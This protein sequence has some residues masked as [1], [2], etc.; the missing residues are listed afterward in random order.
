MGLQAWQDRLLKG[1]GRI[2]T[3]DEFETN[4]LQ[5]RD[6]GFKNINVD[7]MFALPGQ[8]LDDWQET[9]EHVLKLRPEHI[10]AYSLIIEEGTPFY[11]MYE[12]GII[13]ETD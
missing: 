9:I 7:L 10:S 5:A 3:A 13:M 4:F 12:K 11:D 6:A 1:I 2:H 8:T